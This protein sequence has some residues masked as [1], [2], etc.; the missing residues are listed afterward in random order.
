MSKYQNPDAIQH[1]FGGPSAPAFK[2]LIQ[3][4]DAALTRAERSTERAQKAEQRAKLAD[5]KAEHATE[6]LRDALYLKPRNL[7]GHQ[8]P[9]LGGGTSDCAYCKSWMGNSNSGAPKGV[10]QYRDCPG[11]PK[12]RD[13]YDL[14]LKNVK[15]EHAEAP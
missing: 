13:T 1:L 7:G 8:Y 14:L 10:D 2:S 4:V 12:L 5:L 11:N 6:S 3:E 9:G 15:R